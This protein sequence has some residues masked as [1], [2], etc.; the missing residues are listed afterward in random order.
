MIKSRSIFLHF[1]NLDK[2]TK[3]IFKDFFTKENPMLM[4]GES[5]WVPN[6][7]VYETNKGIVVKME[8]TGVS[9][10]QIEILFKGN[11]MVIKG[12]RIDHSTAEKVRCLQL[13]INYG[14][15]Y[16]SIIL[17]SHLEPEKAS[18]RTQDGFLLVFIPFRRQKTRKIKI[19]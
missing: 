18:A 11:A 17:P 6:T 8:L 4:L 7:D 16:R 9:Q 15:F 14:D 13:E 1:D 10:D 19:Q 12:K 5:H 3:D 2:E